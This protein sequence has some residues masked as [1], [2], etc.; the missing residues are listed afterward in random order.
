M[1]AALAVVALAEMEAAV[2]KGVMAEL[3]VAEVQA[4]AAKE[5]ARTIA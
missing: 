4:A 2:P 1:A 5:A 3:L